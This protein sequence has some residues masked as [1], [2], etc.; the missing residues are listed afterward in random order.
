MWANTSY[1]IARLRDNPACADS[2]FSLLDDIA[3]AT[4]KLTPAQKAAL[5]KAANKNKT[6][7]G[8]K[9]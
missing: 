6:P 3:D 4:A 5:T 9:S 8:S 1:Q 2:E 7:K